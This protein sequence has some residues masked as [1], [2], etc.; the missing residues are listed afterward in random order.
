MKVFI[1]R[2]EK[3]D[4]DGV[5]MIELREL[6]EEGDQMREAYRV[7]DGVREAFME[8]PGD[9]RLVR[10]VR[11]ISTMAWRA[12]EYN[13]PKDDLGTL[14]DIMV[15]EGYITEQWWAEHPN[16]RTAPTIDEARQEYI[17]EIARI[18]LAYRVSTRPAGKKPHALDP[19]RVQTFLHP[20]D[21]ALKAMQV[22]LHRHREGI[23]EQT[24]HV[25]QALVN[26][27]RALA[28]DPNTDDSISSEGYSR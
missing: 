25:A 3:S 15:C 23:E 18:K 21:L 24:P 11:P 17:R 4:K 27:E 5:W 16:L 26:M 12:A 8:K 2:C 20:A 19:I 1:D 28:V 10:L 22:I 14:I 13:I 7:T 9:E 6:L